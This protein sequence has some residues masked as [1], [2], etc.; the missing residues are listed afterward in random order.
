MPKQSPTSTLARRSGATLLLLVC[1]AQG[2]GTGAYR[3][4]MEARIAELRKGGGVTNVALYAPSQVGDTSLWIRVPR[5]FT[6]GMTPGAAVNAQRIQPPITLPGLKATWEGTV[7]SDGRK[8][9]FYCYL[10][11]SD[12]DPAGAVQR[13]IKQ[14]YAGVDVTWSEVNDSAGRPW[15]QFRADL[16][17]DW[18]PQGQDDKELAKVSLDGV[19]QVNYRQEGSQY[20]I[21]AWR[22]PQSIESAVNLRALIPATLGSLEAR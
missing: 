13:E 9:P 22:V 3:E 19:F 2:C 21:V 10:A 20:M 7:G 12:N 11:V 1:I 5:K 15:K 6:Q 18:I 17:Q 16:E 4:R 8:L 14:L